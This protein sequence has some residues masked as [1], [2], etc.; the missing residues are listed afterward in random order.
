MKLLFDC[1]CQNYFYNQTTFFFYNQPVSPSL[2]FH[3]NGPSERSARDHD[4]IFSWRN[5][6]PET[7]RG[8]NL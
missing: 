5:V 4:L 1:H 2:L 8:D 3:V 7:K 6:I